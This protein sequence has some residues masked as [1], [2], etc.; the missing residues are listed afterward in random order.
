MNIQNLIKTYKIIG[1]TSNSKEVRKNFAFVAI[2]GEKF[3]GNNYITQAIDNGACLI[4]TESD[5][6]FKK[7]NNKCKIIKVE[8]ARKTLA[9]FASEIYKK[10]PNNLLAVT[11]TNG[12]SSVVHYIGQLASYMSYRASTIGTLGIKKYAN[13]NIVIHKDTGLTTI[14]V[15]ELGRQLED[16]Y[17]DSFDIC[18]VEASSIGLDQYRL[19]GRKF[20]VAGFTSFTQ[21]HLDYHLNMKSYLSAKLRLFSQHQDETGFAIINSGIDD[22][23][24]IVKFL[25][26]NSRRY[27]TYGK[28]GDCKILIHK[29]DI[30]GQEFSIKFNDQEFNAFTSV[31][32]EFQVGNIVL[33]ILMLN[34]IGFDLEKLIQ[35][36]PKLSAPD[37][38]LE[39]T[40]NSGLGSKIFIDY[41]HSP[42]ALENVLKELK[43]TM[44]NND[45][46]LWVVFGC[47]G[48]RDKIKRPLMGEIALSYAD[49]R[50]V[51]DDNP[52]T[53]N[54]EEIRKEII[55]N[56]EGF[57]EVGDR[58]EAISFAIKNMRENDILLIAGKGHEDYQIIGDKK[59]FFSDKD[60]AMEILKKG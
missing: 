49:C 43:K 50:I 29:S 53:E 5:E 36:V 30:N 27:I 47:G 13:N 35:Q 39:R 20:K 33:S 6:F 21:D 7:Y 28:N 37:G 4:I 2:K 22:F 32:G 9:E 45:F 57:I 23:S 8:N 17:K 3:D 1:V 16:L 38:R 15:C 59:L 40:E 48:D 34:Q 25:K 46:K 52:R 41:A 42:D 12:K 10:I 31:I 60:C 19:Y 54:P 26:E 14:D 24:E 18:A 44:K 11:G 58:R 51:T 56:R 55:A